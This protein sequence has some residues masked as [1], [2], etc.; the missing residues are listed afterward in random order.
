MEYGPDRKS[1]QDCNYCSHPGF[2]SRSMS[3][4]QETRWAPTVYAFPLNQEL[5][6]YILMLKACMGSESH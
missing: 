3:G 1:I 5:W 6:M 4:Q 2:A